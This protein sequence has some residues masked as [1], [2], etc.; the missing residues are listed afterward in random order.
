MGIYDAWG[1][2]I[3]FETLTVD[4][5]DRNKFLTGWD[6]TIN[7]S[8]AQSGNYLMVVKGITT[9]GKVISRNTPITLLR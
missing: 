3:Y 2:R 5:T 1:N 6:G 9:A 7:G 8:P 4:I